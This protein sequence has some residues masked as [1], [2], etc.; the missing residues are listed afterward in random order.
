MKFRLN[1]LIIK[2]NHRTHE[3]ID[4]MPSFGFFAATNYFIGPRAA[5]L[6]KEL[7]Y[8][9]SFKIKSLISQT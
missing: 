3:Y 8:L 2:F 4:A 7:N 5:C 9:L 1:V 6:T